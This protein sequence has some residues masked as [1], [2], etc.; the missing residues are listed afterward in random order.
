MSKN[1]I[2]WKKRLDVCTD[3]TKSMT[4]SIKGVVSHIK[5]ENPECSNSHCARHRHQLTTK[6]M[7]RELSNVL[8][9]G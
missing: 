1:K 2:P 7:L 5:K 9:K 4:G 3:G 8:I 6:G